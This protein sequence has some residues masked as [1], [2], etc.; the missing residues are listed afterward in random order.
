MSPSLRQVE[1]YEVSITGE[2]GE[3]GSGIFL[4]FDIT[5]TPGIPHGASAAYLEV[6][7]DGYGQIVVSFEDSKSMEDIV[8]IRCPPGVVQTL[9]KFK[10]MGIAGLP[11]DGAEI[12]FLATVNLSIS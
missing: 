2:A 11:T 4:S 10:T 7:E 9:Q 6:E 3:E 5:D 8:F 12:T 1:N